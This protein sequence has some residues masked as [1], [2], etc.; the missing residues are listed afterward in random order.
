[1]IV[2]ARLVF[3]R[4]TPDLVVYPKD[5]AA[6]ANLTRLLTIGNRRAPKGECWLDFADYLAHAARTA[7]DPDPVLRSGRCAGIFG[8][9]ISRGSSRPQARR[10]LPRLSSTM[11]KIAAAL[12]QLADIGPA[13]R[14]AFARNDRTA[15]ASRRS[16]AF[17]R[18]RHL[19]SR[20]EE[21]ERGGRICWPKTPNVNSN[22]RRK[23]HAS[24][25]TR[26]KRW[27]RACVS[28]TA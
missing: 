12:R 19:H 1:M 28:L 9:L 26:R 7:D 23:S 11:A 15:A 24:T 8:A 17:A 2:G 4:R 25:A 10:G 18:C 22:R 3:P 27:R 13:N 14:G 16:P 20:K 5:R 21:V 6:Y